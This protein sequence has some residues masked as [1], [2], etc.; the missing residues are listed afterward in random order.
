MPPRST[1]DAPA[2]PARASRPARTGAP[3][4]SSDA[5]LFR[6]LPH[7]AADRRAHDRLP[8]AL[9]C[10]VRPE[11]ALRFLGAT[12]ENIS[13]CGAL[14]SL[15]CSKPLGAGETLDLAV[16]FRGD[17]LLRAGETLRATVVRV[18]PSLGGRQRLAVR[19]SQVIDA[20]A[21]PAPAHTA[22]A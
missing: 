6:A 12:T 5:A 18:L 20:A 10:K 15:Q 7:R 17:A 13:R 14:L 22:A 16:A 8:L 1:A 9:P 3:S 2:R 4:A 19:F 21:L 11:A